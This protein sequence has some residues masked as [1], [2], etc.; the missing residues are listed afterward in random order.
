MTASF[1]RGSSFSE[2]SQTPDLPASNEDS[3]ERTGLATDEKERIIGGVEAS[4]AAF[5]YVVGIR[6]GLVETEDFYYFCSGALIDPEYVVTAAHCTEVPDLYV[7]IGSQYG[8]GPG[9]DNGKEIR[10]I[11]ASQHPNKVMT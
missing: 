3:D 8:S 10:V 2:L 7:S 11:K 6:T 4:I 5:P 9:E 1:V